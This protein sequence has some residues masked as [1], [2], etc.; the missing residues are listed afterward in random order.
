[1]RCKHGHQRAQRDV[2]LNNEIAADQQEKERRKLRKKLIQDVYDVS[3][4]GDVHPEI[5]NNLKA[6]RDLCQ[7]VLRSIVPMDL[8]GI[9]D[10]VSDV[11]R[12]SSYRE[13]FTALQAVYGVLNSRNQIHLQWIHRQ[14]S[15]P[16][17]PVLKEDEEK[18]CRQRA[19]R[20]RRDGQ[21]LRHEETKR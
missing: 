1:M 12:Y 16:H 5:E 14:R 3:F 17:L 15:D 6:F 10:D 21:S 4:G 8:G 11:V 18:N 7:F 13:S 19:D 2:P 9:G 20:H